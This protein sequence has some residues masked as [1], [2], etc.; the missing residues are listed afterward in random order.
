[1]F[2]SVNGLTL[3][4]GDMKIKE[5]NFIFSTFVIFINKRLNL[6]FWIV[7]LNVPIYTKKQI[8]QVFFSLTTC[9]ITVLY[10]FYN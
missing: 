6:Y 4:N 8:K 1:M 9:N 2:L 10:F 7:S 5:N 3:F